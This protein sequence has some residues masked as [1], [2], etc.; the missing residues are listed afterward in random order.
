VHL[1]RHLDTLTALFGQMKL[2]KQYRALHALYANTR[3]KCTPRTC[4]YAVYCSRIL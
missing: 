4:R 3:S 1:F 2:S